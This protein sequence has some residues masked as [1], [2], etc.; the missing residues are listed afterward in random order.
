[1]TV[2]TLNPLKV[3]IADDEAPARN[4]L[5]EL[6][7]EISQVN[8]VAE[9]KNGQEALSL[10]NDHQPDIVLLDIRMPGI[11]GIEAAQHLQKLSKSPA[12]IFTT[13]YD[14][15]AI[16][17]FDMNAVDYLLKPI[18]LERLQT[19]LQKARAL[20][21]SQ[22]DALA[23][24]SPKKTHFSITERGR[25]LLVPIAEV[26]FLRAELKYITVHTAEKEY[27]LEESLNNLEQEFGN[28]F[29]R[30]HRNCL[31]AKA[32]ILGYEKRYQEFDEEGNKSS[33]K[34]WVAILKNTDATVAVSRRQQHLI[35]TT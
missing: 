25:I 14:T 15:Y 18:R 16:Q 13:A 4:R 19:A 12:V 35:R 17:A 7:G 33:E 27:L 10:A 20:L 2:P 30:L 28:I 3:L 24:L 23:P 21:P 5:R 1:M 32:Y 31:V 9:A 26:I 34:H 29:I 22:L 8:I 6:L 11:D